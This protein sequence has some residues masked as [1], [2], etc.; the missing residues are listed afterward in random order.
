MEIARIDVKTVED[1]VYESIREGILSSE[2][3]PGEHLHLESI[4]EQLGVSTMPLRGAIRRL[5]A[6]GLAEML[7]R[8]GARVSELSVAEFDEI[9]D[10]RLALETTIVRVAAIRIDDADIDGLKAVYAEYDIPHTDEEYRSLEWD[11]FLRCYRASGRERTVDTIVTC[12]RLTERYVR[13]AAAPFD[14]GRARRSLGMLIAACEAHDPNAA[15]ASIL[16]G[17]APYRD[18][19]R[20]TLNERKAYARG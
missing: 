8:R 17:V 9:E 12:A 11:A 5:S 10:M 4:A 2:Y 3:Q 15:E 16:A 20:D 18:L 1:A 19:V 7:P 14:L 6:E 13:L